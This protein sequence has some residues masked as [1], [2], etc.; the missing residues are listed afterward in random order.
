MVQILEPIILSETVEWLVVS[1]PAGWLTIPG[2]PGLGPK[3]PKREEAPIPVLSEWASRNRKIWVTHRLDRET[4]GVVLFALTEEAHRK[5]NGWFSAHQM[6]KVYDALAVGSPG[7]PMFKSKQPIEGAASVTQFEVREKFASGAFLVRARPSTG[8]RHQIRIHLSQEGYPILGDS[9]YKGPKSFAGI[10]ISRVALHAA[11]L[12]LP[13]GES[14]EAEWPEDFS[15]WV[16]AL[17][18]LKAGERHG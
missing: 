15:G 7:M 14:F 5:A 13:S 16:S 17:R 11:K 12:E 1:K 10:E 2:R 6:K 8:R 18:N 3:R 9:L 4:S